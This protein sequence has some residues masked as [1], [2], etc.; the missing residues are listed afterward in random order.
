VAQSYSSEL[1]P[2]RIMLETLTSPNVLSR[3]VRRACLTFCLRLLVLPAVTLADEVEPLDGGAV[4][5]DIDRAG[6]VGGGP[7][8]AAG[9]LLCIDR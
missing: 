8:S 5:G 4:E 2:V 9:D 7:G 6:M 1:R 3:K